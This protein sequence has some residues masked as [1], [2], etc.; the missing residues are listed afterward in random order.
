MGRIVYD[1]IHFA[2]MLLIVLFFLRIGKQHLDENGVTN[3]A[4]N[5]LIH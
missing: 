1:G 2:A 3:K 4:L 5:Y